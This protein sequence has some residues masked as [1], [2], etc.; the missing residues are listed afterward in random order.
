ML[1]SVLIAVFGLQFAKAQIF[2]EDFHLS[3]SQDVSHLRVEYHTSNNVLENDS[4]TYS[5]WKGQHAIHVS[6]LIQ[7]FGQNVK[8]TRTENG[9]TFD[10]SDSSLQIKIEDDT[11]TFALISVERNTKIAER[12]DDCFELKS[13]EISWYGGPQQRY[14]YWPVERLTFDDYSYVTKQVD[15]CAIAERYWLNSQ[16]VFIYVDA[17]APLFLNQIANK[18]LCLTAEKKLPYYAHDNE[19]ISFNYKIGI[20]SNAR[21]AHMV[22]IDKFLKKPTG[23][24]DERMVRHP[25]WSTWARYYKPINESILHSLADEIL[26]HGF[27]NSQLEIDDLWEICYGSTEFDTVK[28]P[29]MKSLTDALKA[30]GF[31]VTL[32]VH[33]FINK[34]C[35]PYYTEALNNGH[36]VLNQNNDP[37][38]QWWNSDVGEASYIDFTKPATAKWYSDKLT[39]LAL[40]AG[41]DSFKFDAGESSF[42]PSDP[43]LNATKARHPLA[44]TTD[45]LNT[46]AKFGPMIEVRSGFRNQEMPV[47]LRINDKDSDWSWDNGLPTLVTTLL[48]LNMV[49]YPLLLPDMIGGNGYGNNPPNKELF[50]RWLQANVFMPSLQFSFVPWD[51][52]DETISISHKFT[53]LHAEYTDVIMERFRLATTNGDPVNPPIWW[54]APDDRI[55]QLINDEFLLG[56]NILVAPVLQEGKVSRDIYLPRGEWVDQNGDSHTG[57]I[58]LKDYPADLSVLPYFIKSGSSFVRLNFGLMVVALLAICSLA[59]V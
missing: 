42:S 57:P 36:F 31:R 5:L 16:G 20:S 22:A 53:D 43:A 45:Y 8:A 27:N 58:W 6:Q 48:M 28:F 50:L 3:K 40:A 51:Y 13:Q 56:D 59:K 17:E 14:Q 26:L 23:I 55:A 34:V 37:S 32:W 9:F 54:I 19:P 11:S 18:S 4:M 10:G 21:A 29:N 25:I 47:F 7:K 15:N 12:L 49:G 2:V 38:A 44:I 35:E 41:I 39:A 52:D 1:L 30:K 33:P 46:V 24:P